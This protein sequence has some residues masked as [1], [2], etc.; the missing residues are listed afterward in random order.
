MF[1][2]RSFL[3][4]LNMSLAAPFSEGV[5]DVSIWSDCKATAFQVSPFSDGSFQVP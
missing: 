4:R 3:A 5:Y 2:K 1:C